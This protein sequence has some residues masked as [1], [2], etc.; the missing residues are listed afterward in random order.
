MRGRRLFVA[1]VV[2]VMPVLGGL[3]SSPAHAHLNCPDKMWPSPAVTAADRQKD[4]NN[5][6]VV[7]KHYDTA[8]PTSNGPDDTQDDII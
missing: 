1:L 7:C 3:V 8:T 6:G 2:A 4:K 5:N